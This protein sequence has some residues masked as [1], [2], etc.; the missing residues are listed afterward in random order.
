MCVGQSVC[1]LRGGGGDGG[2]GG[3][4]CQIVLSQWQIIFTETAELWE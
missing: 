3:W 2:G 1:V 4:G